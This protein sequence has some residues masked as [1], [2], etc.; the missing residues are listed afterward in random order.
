MKSI[1]FGLVCLTFASAQALECESQVENSHDISINIKINCP[2]SDEFQEFVKSIPPEG[3]YYSSFNEWKS[4]FV[5]N[6]NQLIHLVE[7]GKIFNSSCSIN[8]DDHL[9]PKI[10]EE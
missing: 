8:T 7:S 5:N 3:N 9:P 6:M 1:L 10:K 2:T 4:S